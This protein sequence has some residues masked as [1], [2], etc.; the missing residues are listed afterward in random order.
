MMKSS[1]I[2][3]SRSVRDQVQIP[4]VGLRLVHPSSCLEIGGQFCLLSRLVD[5]QT[6]M[7]MITKM[8]DAMQKFKADSRS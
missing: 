3:R 8:G 5:G 4:G 6:V 2:L 7:A 1:L